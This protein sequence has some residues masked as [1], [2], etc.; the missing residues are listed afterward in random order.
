MALIGRR[1]KIVAAIFVACTAVLAICY[2]TD[3]LSTYY[4]S[5]IAACLT[6]AFVAVMLIVG[7][8]R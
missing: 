4:I 3:T 8:N 1:G 6:V 7:R 2:A 5:R